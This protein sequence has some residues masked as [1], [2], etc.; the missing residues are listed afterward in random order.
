MFRP[1]FRVYERVRHVRVPTLKRPS[2]L[3][4]VLAMRCEPQ[5]PHFVSVWALA[6]GI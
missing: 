3:G 6:S 2:G 1:R 5:Q 4:R